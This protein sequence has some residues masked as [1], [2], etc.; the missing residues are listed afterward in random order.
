MNSDFK[1]I[2]I[3]ENNQ[4][5]THGVLTAIRNWRYQ[6]KINQE[7]EKAR[8]SKFRSVLETSEDDVHFLDRATSIDEATIKK[9]GIITSDE[10][11]SPDFW[12]A[13]ECAENEES[14]FRLIFFA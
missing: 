8:K 13:T 1:R 3:N 4:Y 5:A 7:F 12:S 2:E 10:R 14:T 6:L 9:A 11:T